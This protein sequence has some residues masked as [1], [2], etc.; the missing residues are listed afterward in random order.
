MSP[1]NLL[2]DLFPVTCH[3]KLRSWQMVLRPVILKRLTLGQGQRAS[4]SEQRTL[5]S[6]F[7][8]ARITS[9]QETI[10]MSKMCLSM[11]RQSWH[12]ESC[13][14]MLIHVES[15]SL[16]VKRSDA[17][18]SNEPNVSGLAPCSATL[19]Q[20]PEPPGASFQ[21]PLGLPTPIERWKKTKGPRGQS[22]RS[23][24]LKI[25][26]R[27]SKD[28]LFHLVTSKIDYLILGY[29]ECIHAYPYPSFSTL[30]ARI[31]WLRPSRT[32][33]FEQMCPLVSYGNQPEGFL[34]VCNLLCGSAWPTK[35]VL[36]RPPVAVGNWDVRQVPASCSPFHADR[37]CR[38]LQLV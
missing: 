1:A 7:F 10:N 18:P 14:I 26:Q 28:R 29:S 34:I 20:R 36:R 17:V 19:L 13:W 15:Y 23:K 9:L 32:A 11:D 33:I 24:C 16:P 4:T 21:L 6:I 5:K 35:M 8:E 30:N 37:N 2:F 31:W 22:K 3:A 25:S 38:G 27:M 12:V